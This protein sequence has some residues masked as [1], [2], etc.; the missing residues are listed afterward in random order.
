RCFFARTILIISTV[1]SIILISV[2][3]FLPFKEKP[4]PRAGLN[5]PNNYETTNYP[6]IHTQ[7]NEPQQ[8]RLLDFPEVPLSVQHCKAA[9][10]LRQEKTEISL[11]PHLL[12]SPSFYHP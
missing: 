7:H 5:Q 12:R 6:L 3:I 1:P 11:S 8:V 4:D 2:T 9:R 10:K